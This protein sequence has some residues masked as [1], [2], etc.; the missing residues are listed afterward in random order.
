MNKRATRGYQ[1]Q[2]LDL[3]TQLQISIDLDDERDNRLGRTAG[4]VDDAAT[5]RRGNEPSGCG[6]EATGGVRPQPV[7]DGAGRTRLRRAHG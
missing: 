6:S 1:A 2:M 4:K 7:R 5:Y 3:D